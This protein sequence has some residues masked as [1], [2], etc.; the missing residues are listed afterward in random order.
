MSND[1]I[2]FNTRQAA[3]YGSCH[4]DTVRRAAEDKTLHGTQRTKAGHWR[5][6]V[7]CLNAWLAGEKCK[8]GIGRAA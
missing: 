8:H 6:H 1:R 5:F 7:D 3:D 4:P 2:W